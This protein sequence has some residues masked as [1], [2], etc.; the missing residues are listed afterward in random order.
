M[1]MVRLGWLPA[2]RKFT[3]QGFV[4]NELLGSTES[5]PALIISSDFM[6]EGQELCDRG[7]G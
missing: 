5:I 1:V 2:G 7:Q 6:E 3:W 4:L